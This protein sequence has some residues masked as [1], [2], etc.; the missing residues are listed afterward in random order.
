MNGLRFSEVFRIYTVTVCE[1]YW[2]FLNHRNTR[3]LTTFQCH[4]KTETMTG[5]VEHFF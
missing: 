3:F 5:Q 2:P 4:P 1:G